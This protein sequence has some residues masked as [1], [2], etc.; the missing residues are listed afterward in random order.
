NAEYCID[1]VLNNKLVLYDLENQALGVSEYDCSSTI[2]LKDEESG[3][4]YQAGGSNNL[5][6]YP[7]RYH[8][9]ISSSP[10]QHFGR[11]IQ[12]VSLSFML[13]HYV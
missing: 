12:L 8:K 4:I 2:G 6:S 13:Y 3:F 11:V 1:L 10:T 5:S 7:T 9:D